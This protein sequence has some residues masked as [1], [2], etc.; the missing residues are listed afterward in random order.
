M[1]IEIPHFPGP[2]SSPPRPIGEDD[3]RGASAPRAKDGRTAALAGPYEAYTDQAEDYDVDTPNLGWV[4]P[5]F[6][7]GLLAVAG[8]QLAV[9]AYR[10][11]FVLGDKPL[12]RR[13]AKAKATVFAHLP[14]ESD[15]QDRAWR[16]A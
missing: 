11:A 4:F 12:S 5:P 13:S 14:A 15:R 7:A 6:L 10:D 9:L 3:G 8:R 16:L 2:V 1:W